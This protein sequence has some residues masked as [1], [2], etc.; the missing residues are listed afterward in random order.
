MVARYSGGGGG[1]GA[2][3]FCFLQYVNKNRGN[4]GD[5][6]FGGTWYSWAGIRGSGIGGGAG[7]RGFYSS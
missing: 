2:V 7:I 3:L 1:G 6:V 4:N 5:T